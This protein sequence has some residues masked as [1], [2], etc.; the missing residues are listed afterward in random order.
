MVENISTINSVSSENEILN[1][2]EV[3]ALL[4]VSKST[5]YKLSSSNS[6]PHFKPTKG[7]LFFRRKD[8]LTWITGK[9]ETCTISNLKNSEEN[10]K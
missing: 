8:I 4:K 1:F 7:K 3:R 2:N 5:L 9:S 10:G 6:I